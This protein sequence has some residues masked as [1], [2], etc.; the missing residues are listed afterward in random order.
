MVWVIEVA[1]VAESPRLVLIFEL[2][3]MQVG[4]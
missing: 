4:C 2:E 1:V 3:I